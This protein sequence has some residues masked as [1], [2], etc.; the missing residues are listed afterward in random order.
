MQK[1]NS[2]ADFKSKQGKVLKELRS[3]ALT[4]EEMIDVVETQN[5]I[6]KWVLRLVGVL[7]VT[8]GFAG[9]LTPILMVLS[10]IP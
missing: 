6:L 4:G 7:L 1:G 5:N 8:G 3:G 10:I 2:F 9:L